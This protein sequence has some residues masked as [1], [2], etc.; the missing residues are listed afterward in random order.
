M[1]SLFC[2]TNSVSVK[3]CFPSNR[4]PTMLGNDDTENKQEIMYVRTFLDRERYF[5]LIERSIEFV[6][7]N[8]RTYT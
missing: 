4:T 6:S 8:R 7:I 1:V 5:I 3:R 2:E